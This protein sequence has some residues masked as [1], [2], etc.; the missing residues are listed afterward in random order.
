MGKQKKFCHKNFCQKFCI[1]KIF[2]HHL[3]NQGLLMGFRGINNGNIIENIFDFLINFRALH[4]SMED[5][6]EVCVV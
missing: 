2:S 1:F 4:Q 3:F 5:N 6:N